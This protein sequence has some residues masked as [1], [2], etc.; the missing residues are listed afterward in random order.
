MTGN[1]RRGER[2]TC[3]ASYR[4]PQNLTPVNGSSSHLPRPVLAASPPLSLLLLRRP[5]ELFTVHSIAPPVYQRLGPSNISSVSESLVDD[6]PFKRN[7]PARRANDRE[8][9]IRSIRCT[10]SS[11][12]C[13]YPDPDCTF[14]FLILLPLNQ[15]L[16]S[17]SKRK[18]RNDCRV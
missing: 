10:C 12:L 3:N 14:S 7:P 13:H 11:N 9:G 2:E 15:I 17:Q 1:R 16:S 5:A 18:Q 4:L 6:F 8:R